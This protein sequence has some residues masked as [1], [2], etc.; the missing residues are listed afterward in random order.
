[1]NQL[2]ADA[3]GNIGTSSSRSTIYRVEQCKTLKCASSA[4]RGWLDRSGNPTIIIQRRGL[5]V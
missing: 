2:M 4:K 5:H 1:M 3:S